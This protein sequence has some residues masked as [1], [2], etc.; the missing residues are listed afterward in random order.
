MPMQKVPPHLSCRILSGTRRLW[1]KADL[2]SAISL[3]LHIIGSGFNWQRPHCH[4]HVAMKWHKDFQCPCSVLNNQLFHSNGG[5]EVSG[6]SSCRDTEG[7]WKMLCPAFALTL[8]PLLE[9]LK[10]LTRHRVTK[11]IN[12]CRISS[13]LSPGIIIGTYT[14]H[15]NLFNQYLHIW[16][17]VQSEMMLNPGIG[18]SISA[19]SL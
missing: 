16:H 9:W 8:L 15:L 1:K 12:V 6:C 5:V 7:N 2:H 10:N 13:L 18:W 11:W 3:M 14:F 17:L 4:S 19:C